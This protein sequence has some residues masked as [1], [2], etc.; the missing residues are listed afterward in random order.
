MILIESTFGEQVLPYRF[1]FLFDTQNATW[2]HLLIKYLSMLGELFV[3]LSK[4][5][6]FFD[7]YLE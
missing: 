5:Y 6:A 7:Y 3:D 1:I 4:P 2:V